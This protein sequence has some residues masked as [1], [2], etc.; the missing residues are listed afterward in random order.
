MKKV[1]QKTAGLAGRV[2]EFLRPDRIIGVSYINTLN[3]REFAHAQFRGFNERSVEYRFVFEQIAA[4]YPHTVL[5]VGP[6]V[7][8]LPSLMHTCGPQVW[9]IDN[10]ED[11]WPNGMFN[12]HYHVLNDNIVDPKIQQNFD[13]I[14]CISTL[15]HIEDFKG[16]VASMFRL[17]KPGGNLVLTFPYTEKKFV[18]DVYGLPASNAFKKRPVYKAHSFSRTEIESFAKENNAE[19]VSQEYWQFWTGAEW[20]TGERLPLPKRVTQND[21]HQHSCVLLA[22]R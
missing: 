1:L 7:T 17:L 20:S 12:R 13:M 10:I 9:A 18:D 21:L 5:D 19:V 8:A 15:E 2:F 22:K 16:A 3:K 6:G 4:Y 11:Y 14:T